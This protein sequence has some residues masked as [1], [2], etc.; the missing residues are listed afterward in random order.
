MADA[1]VAASSSKATGGGATQRIEKGLDVFQ[2]RRPFVASHSSG[3][4]FEV[5]ITDPVR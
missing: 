3:P 2:I 1:A 4:R 5:T